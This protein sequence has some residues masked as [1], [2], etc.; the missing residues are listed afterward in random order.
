MLGDNTLDVAMGTP[1]GFLQELVSVRAEQDRPQ[2]AVL[3]QMLHRLIVTPDFESL[4]D[5][6]R[7]ANN[8]SHSP[9]QHR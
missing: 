5:S 1:C 3:G 8:D 7:L 9:E 6:N 4:L 2:M